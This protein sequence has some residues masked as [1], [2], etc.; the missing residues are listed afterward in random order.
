[1]CSQFEIPAS[2]ARRAQDVAMRDRAAP[3]AARAPGRG[4]GRGGRERRSAIRRSPH[5]SAGQK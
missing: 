2:S 5:T 1:M 4:A 3:C